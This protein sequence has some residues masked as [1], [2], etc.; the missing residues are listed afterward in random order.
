M[1]SA[2]QECGGATPRARAQ[3]PAAPPVTLQQYYKAQQAQQVLQQQVQQAEQA[4][5]AQVSTKVATQGAC[6]CLLCTVDIGVAL[7]RVET[8]GRVSAV[9][10]N[11]LEGRGAGTRP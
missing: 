2:V 9:A 5:K 1:S 6:F 10:S 8:I 7:P 3:A 11:F 4:A